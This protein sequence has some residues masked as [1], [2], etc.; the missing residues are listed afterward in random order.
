MRQLPVE[1]RCRGIGAQCR[2]HLIDGSSWS[3]FVGVDQE[4]MPAA[5]G[6]AAGSKVVTTLKAVRE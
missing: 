2:Q 1:S 3:R 4:T 6:L 5:N